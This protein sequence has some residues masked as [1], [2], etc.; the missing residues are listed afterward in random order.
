MKIVLVNNS[1]SQRSSNFSDV[2]SKLLKSDRKVF[3]DNRLAG[4]NS[5]I[6]SKVSHSTDRM[7]HIKIN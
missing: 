3:F 1:S 7:T 2:G 5:Q 6:K 4:T